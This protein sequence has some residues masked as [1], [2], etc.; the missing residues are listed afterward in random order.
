[1]IG[2]TWDASFFAPS[3][4]AREVARSVARIVTWGG[5]GYD[6][7]GLA[8]GFL[9]T[10]DLLLT[11]HHVVPT[12]ADG[13]GLAANFLYESSERGVNRGLLYRLDPNRFF[14][15][16]PELDFALVGI[17]P[18]GDGG[19]PITE[20]GAIPLI[21]STGK[22]LTGHPIN[23]IQ[24][25]N[26]G[27]RQYAVT[28]NRLVQILEE[29]GFLHYETDTARGSSGS[30]IFNADWEVVGLHHCG[31]PAMQGTDVMRRDGAVWDPEGDDDDDIHWLANEGTR[32]SFI[33]AA[34]KQAVFQSATEQELATRFI[35]GAADPL[36][37]QLPRTIGQPLP[38]QP[39]GIPTK[40]DV[41]MSGNVFNISGNV[42]INVG[43][44][45]EKLAAPAVVVERKPVPGFVEKAQ[46]FDPDYSERPG[47]DPMFLGVE[48][49]APT[50]IASRVQELYLVGEYRSHLAENRNVPNIDKPEWADDQPLT[51]PYHHFSLQTNKQYRMPMWTALNADYREE[52][53][54]DTRARSE[55]GGESW[56]LDR[57]VPTPYQLTDGDIYRPAQNFDRGHIVRR[58]DSAWGEPGIETE[59]ANADTYHW[60]NCT[61]QHEL[62]NQESP[63]GEEY[64]G[65]KGIWGFFEGELEKEVTAGGGQAVIFSGPV[66]EPNLPSI[67]FGRGE[68]QYPR[69][70]W[71]VVIAPESNARRP[72]LLAYGFVFDQSSVIREF[73]VGFREALRLKPFVRQR[74]TLEEISRLA[75][76][77]FADALHAVDQHN[78]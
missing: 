55:F 30:P 25:P 41:P 1:M 16:H 53:R 12:R 43:T 32:A 19:E 72:A 13:V 24:H 26:G 28:N 5:P 61:P 70:F 44:Q 6:P 21:G 2:T 57:R 38:I 71:K 51:L 45:L 67:D 56:R 60:T 40:G 8:T 69:K 63:R 31:I 49:P 48:V 76:V 35:A 68:V 47:Y 74:K 62:F 66:L 4:R 64:A 27:P 52:A 17:E 22:I 73:G 50:V 37:K 77:A 46:N 23:V 54:G 65:R 20:L 10:P 3:E 7:V 39:V 59:Y 42:T 18:R 14:F 78:E 11:N 75:G 29:E 58:E 36:E 34:V 9:V 33:V 15:S